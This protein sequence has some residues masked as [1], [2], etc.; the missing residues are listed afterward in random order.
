[1]I[2]KI[3]CAIAIRMTVFNYVCAS[4]CGYGPMSEVSTEA[5]RGHQTSASYKWL[6]LPM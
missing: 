1:M 2:L 4:V 3:P 5:R 6:Q